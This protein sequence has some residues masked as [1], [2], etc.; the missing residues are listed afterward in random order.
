M[1]LFK[2]S[3]ANGMYPKGAEVML[4]DIVANSFEQVG[5]GS[6]ITEKPKKATKKSK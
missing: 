4:N 5:L 6:V 2:F 3:K 1:K